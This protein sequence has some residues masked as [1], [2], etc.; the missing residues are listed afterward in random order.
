MANVIENLIRWDEMLEIIGIVIC[1]IFFL[2]IGLCA[3]AP[4]ILSSKISQME[5]KYREE[6]KDGS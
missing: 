6:H 4:C 3:I 1:I 2:L 5:E